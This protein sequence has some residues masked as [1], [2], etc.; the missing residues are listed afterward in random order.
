MFPELSSQ[1]FLLK[2]IL[3]TDQQFIFQG[4]SHPQVIEHYGVSYHSFE[5]T[6]IQM[7]FYDE[8]FR[9]GSGTWWKIVD[10]LTNNNVGA[11]GFNN[12]QLKH[13][14]AELG[15]WLLPEYWGLGIVR[16]VLPVVITYL[17]DVLKIHRIE[18]QVEDGNAR[19]RQALEKLGFQ[20]E[21]L[22]RDCEIKNGRYISLH[23]YSLVKP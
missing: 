8:I 1:R 22:L 2:Q 20:H 11:I 18:A 14:K 9:E 5:S 3:P 15:Y 6:S 12:Y 4:L 13:S 10:R 16:E 21:G 17:Q 7:Q 19:S 23:I